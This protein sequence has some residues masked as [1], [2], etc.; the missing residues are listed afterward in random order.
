M[1]LPT[2][3][4]LL[5]GTGA[6]LLVALFVT[7]AGLTMAYEPPQLGAGTIKDPANGTTA[8]AIQGFHFQGE[9]NSKKPARLLEVSGTGNITELWNG[10]DRGA[11]WFYDVDPLDDG[12]LLVTT[13]NP[14]ERG[15]PGGTIVYEYD[16]K[17]R[18]VV[19]KQSFD[20]V[21]THDV[22]MLNEHELIVA[23]MRN[24][25]EN[26]SVNDD[27]LFVYNLTSD[28][29][30]WEWK[31]RNH[32]PESTDNGADSEDWTHV[33][34]VDEIEEG[35]YLVS[36]R[37]FDQA[38][39][40]NR[41]T[42][43]IEMR[44]GSDDAHGIMNEQHNPDYLEG[45][46]GTPTIL[47]AD[48]ENDRIVEYER[49]CGEADPR[50]GAGTPP[51]DCEW[52]LVWELGDQNLNWPRDADR[53]PNGN[54]LIVDSMNHRVIEVDP[55]GEIV[56]EAHT[57]WGPYD[58]ER[59]KYGGG[60]N[61][62]TMRELGVNGSYSIADAESGNGSLGGGSAGTASTSFPQWIQQTTAGWPG[63]A[64][65][66]EFAETWEGVSQWVKPVW[67]APWGFVALV[68]ALCL[69]VAWLLAELVYRRQRVYRWAG[70]LRST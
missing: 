46:N 15:P 20:A 35:R 1:D 7:A 60:S 5:R 37:N 6:V 22:D 70:S 66:D 36:P 12:N 38:I 8:V 23:N 16:P 47:V 62:P 34:D 41:S 44:L 51:E 27:R 11:S 59:V 2:R 30:T 21:D 48:S 3:S 63:E 49:D 28:E 52:N 10:S 65:F 55:Q 42:K 25:A 43:A 17:T 14:P 29:V 13:T 69:S 24:R 4:T 33:N 64:A 54:T 31:F 50:L 45:P 68:G 67:M 32:Y 39:V 53:L 18:D 9:G 26:G 40:V 56:W 58:A 19:W 61:G 57:P